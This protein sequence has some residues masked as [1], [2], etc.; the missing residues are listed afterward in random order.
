MPL[1]DLTAFEQAAKE[2]AE[3]TTTPKIKLK[4]GQTIETLIE[5]ARQLV[6]EKLGAYR[7]R[8][9]CVTDIEELKKFFNQTEELI[10]IDTETTGLN[11]FSDQLVGIC[12]GN[13]KESIYVPINHKSPLYNNRLK[14]QISEDDI[15]ELFK[16]EIQNENYKWIYHNAKFDLNFLRSFL[17]FNMPNPYWDTMICGN[18]LYQDEEHSLKYLYNKYI[19]EED[20]GVNRFDT[21]FSG[22]TFDYVPIDIATI[23]AAK[24]ALMTLQLYYYQRD[25]LNKSDMKG[26][27]YV[28]ENIEMPLIPILVDMNR[29]GVNMNQQMI[30]ELYEKYNQRLEKAKVE[31]YKEIEPYTEAINKYRIQNYTKKLDDPISISSPAQLSILFYDILK[32]KTK[33][34]KGTGVHELEEINTPLTKALLEYR[35]MSKLI[36]AFLVALPKNIEPTT[37][38]IHTSLNQYGAAT[39]RFSSSSP[40]RKLGHIEVILYENHVNS[41]E[42]MVA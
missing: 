15:K 12:L 34:G 11:P 3:N 30:Q 26:V 27:K 2:V 29:T 13:D 25:I 1:F 35:K 5:S 14:N 21:L 4:K 33:S 10:S 41:G 36:D 39:G 20:E 24:D 19:A 8:S 40:R 42:A 18:M 28:F 6:N 38:K 32:Y 22:L 9:K 31:V 23:Y 16:Q 7:D 37:G 17:G